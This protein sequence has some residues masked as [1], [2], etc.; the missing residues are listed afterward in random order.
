MWLLLKLLTNVFTSRF[1]LT[2]TDLFTTVAIPVFIFYFL[3]DSN[4]IN[5]V[6]HQLE[7]FTDQY[8]NNNSKQ[9]ETI[10]TDIQ[11]TL[12][13]EKIHAAQ[14]VPIGTF[15]CQLRNFNEQWL[16][17]KSAFSSS[18][19][20]ANELFRIIFDLYSITGCFGYTFISWCLQW[21]IPSKILSFDYLI[22]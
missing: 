12:K 8:S 18:W 3:P 16:A 9:Q 5:T 21:K 10:G 20:F 22:F 1:T 17:F 2:K 15:S 14:H 7:P 6:S 4:Q 13:L 19:L 11:S